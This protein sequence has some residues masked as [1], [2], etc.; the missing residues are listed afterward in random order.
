[1]EFYSLLQITEQKQ[2]CFTMKFV[3]QGPKL[4]FILK[5]YS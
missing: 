3:K 2:I 1:M 5:K 4:V